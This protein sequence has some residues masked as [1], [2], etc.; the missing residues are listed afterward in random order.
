MNVAN[1][2]DKRAIGG[3]GGTG[4]IESIVDIVGTGGGGRGD[5]AE[6][7]PAT[8]PDVSDDALG[9]VASEVGL[10]V[11]TTVTSGS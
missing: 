5:D 1:D 2:V 11:V 7:S 8:T 6:I 10:T 3:G 4:T 9:E